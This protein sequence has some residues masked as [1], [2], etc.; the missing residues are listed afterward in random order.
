VIRQQLLDSN[1][2]LQKAAQEIEHRADHDEL[3]GA[4]NRRPFWQRLEQRIEASATRP[5]ALA[6]L[7][8]D[9]FKRINDNYGHDVGDQVLQAFVKIASGCIGEQD[10][11]ARF[12]GEE[13]VLLLGDAHSAKT[14]TE[15]IRSRVAEAP[16]N[17][18]AVHL[19]VSVS[20][21]VAIFDLCDSSKSLL[22]RADE[23]LYRAKRE[24]RN[25]VIAN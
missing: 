9:H 23:A 3:T 14:V 8:L 13:F 20:I 10:L 5:F 6:I 19:R 2:R 21:G 11:L 25:R 24:G 22:K 1:S 4:H 15:R 17:V 18:I 16:W 12:G 7:D